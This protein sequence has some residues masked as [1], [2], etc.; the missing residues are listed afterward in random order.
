MLLGTVSM[1]RGPIGVGFCLAGNLKKL[2]VWPVSLSTSNT[3]FW[4]A[5]TT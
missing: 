4:L 2:R 3:V 5:S 1:K